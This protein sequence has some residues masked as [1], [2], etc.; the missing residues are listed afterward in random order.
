MKHDTTMKFFIGKKIH[1][2]VIYNFS[3]YKKKLSNLNQHI[4]LQYTIAHQ[5][6]TIHI[7]QN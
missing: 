2:V 7:P 6:N 5:N 1:S 3:P 4:I